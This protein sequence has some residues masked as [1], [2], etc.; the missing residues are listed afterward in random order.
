[1][2][3]HLVLI[4]GA[5]CRLLQVLRLLRES[6]GNI[7]DD[8]QLVSTLNSAKAT[9]GAAG[10]GRANNMRPL[11]LH[12]SCPGE[13]DCIVCAAGQARR[14]RAV[15]VMPA[16]CSTVLPP[17]ISHPPA[18]TGFI[19]ARVAEAEDTRAS[20]G[21]AREVYRPA[22]RRASLLYFCVASLSL[23]DTMYQYS[24]AYF[25][26]LNS[27]CL[28]ASTPSKHLDARLKAITDYTTAFIYSTVCR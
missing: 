2:P 8:E 22:P 6:Q 16:A 4:V 11:A 24:L 28:A 12:Q 26:Q 21:A 5:C 13:I 18:S 10:S 7:L 27:H 14:P 1:M 15:L 25:V 23:L 17:R 20:I 19:Q 3:P 9:S